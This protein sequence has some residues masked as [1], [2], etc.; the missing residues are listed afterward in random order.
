MKAREVAIRLMDSQNE[1]TGGT[2]TTDTR[3]YALRSLSL[4][5]RLLDQV[6]SAGDI[7]GFSADRVRPTLLDVIELADDLI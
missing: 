3:E 2:S 4:T 6:Y 5:N 7:Y 1:N